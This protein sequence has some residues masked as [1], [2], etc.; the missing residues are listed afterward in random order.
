MKNLIAGKWVDASDGRVIDV[1]NPAN[2]ELIDTVP[3]ATALDIDRAVKFAYE[4]HKSWA[5]MSIY[6][7]GEILKKFATLIEENKEELATLLCK[8][9]GKPITE[10][11]AEIANTKTFVNGYVEKSRHMYGTVIP[12]G[13]E[14]GQEKTIQITEACPLGVVACIIPFNFP[15][16]QFIVL[17]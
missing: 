15:P 6:D 1:T 10:A 12:E 8:E 7:R 9:T 4:A 16:S 3:N 11:R 13:T 2:N 14:P 5:K 17:Q